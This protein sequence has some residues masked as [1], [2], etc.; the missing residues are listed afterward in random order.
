MDIPYTGFDKKRRTRTS[1]HCILGRA[2]TR[3]QSD[4]RQQTNRPRM[5]LV[6][7]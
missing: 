1:S 5:R 6:R 2:P 4:H 3:S 7:V